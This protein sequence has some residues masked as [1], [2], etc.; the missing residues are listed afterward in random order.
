MAA[1]MR[2][3]WPQLLDLTYP[4]VS[5]VTGRAFNRVIAKSLEEDSQEAGY[6]TLMEDLWLPC[7]VVTTDVSEMKEQ[8]HINGCL[9]R[10]VRASMSLQG[11]LPPLCDPLTGNLLLDGGYCNNLPI[12]VMRRVFGPS[13]IIGVDV[14]AKDPQDF[15]N[16]GDACS[17][18][19]VCLQS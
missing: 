19:C 17:G 3:L 6:E 16:Y 4:V 2:Y 10:Y 18:W 1:R 5:L 14:E 8:V 7:F 15:T 11:Y 12:D 13:R 9:W